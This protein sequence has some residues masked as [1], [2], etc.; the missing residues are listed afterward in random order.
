[1]K[2][3]PVTVSGAGMAGLIFGG[4]L[5]AVALKLVWDM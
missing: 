1:M 3:M 5:L 2:A 4:L